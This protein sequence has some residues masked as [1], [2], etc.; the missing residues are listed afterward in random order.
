L[1]VVL[2]AVASDV[3]VVSGAGAAARRVGGVRARCHQRP[4][5]QHSGRPRARCVPCAGPGNP[6]GRRGPRRFMTRGTRERPLRMDPRPEPFAGNG[7]W[8]AL[9]HLDRS[10]VQTTPST[11]RR[12]AVCCT[13]WTPS[14]V[15][16]GGPT[17][18][19]TPAAETFLSPTRASGRH[20]GL[21]HG[22]HAGGSVGG[23][24]RV[25]VGESAGHRDLSGH[26][27]RETGLCR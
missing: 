10:S 26:R 19:A 6:S 23:R 15:P 5:E 8:R 1:W 21:P 13:H 25:V 12:T 16:I 11:C 17:I 14:P 7:S 9:V 27:G 22:N 20:D 2:T 4:D 18:R 24:E 3:V